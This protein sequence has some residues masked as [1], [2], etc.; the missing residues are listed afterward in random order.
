M[1]QYFQKN[2]RAAKIGK[3]WI[4]TRKKAEAEAKA[5]EETASLRLGL[6]S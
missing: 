2:E 3:M 1:G 6:S 5:E 4:G